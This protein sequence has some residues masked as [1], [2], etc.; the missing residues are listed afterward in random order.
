MD[1]SVRQAA[2]TRSREGPPMR[3]SSLAT[4]LVAFGLCLTGCSAASH[5]TRTLGSLTYNDHG[6]TA[7]HSTATLALEADSYYFNP[8]FVQG[9]PGQ[10]LALTVHNDAGV[11]HNL[12]IPSQAVDQDIPAQGTVTITVT[13][14]AAGGVAF[15]CKFHTAQGM[16][17]QLLA[18]ATPPQA[19]S[20]G[21][22]PTAKPKGPASGYPRY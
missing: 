11:T 2:R 7:A 22:A 18:G 21:P 5:T 4:V 16:N 15:F 12:S 6:T 8:T 3:L 13:L 1:T 9:D 17:G 14:P 19:L 10:P 20:S